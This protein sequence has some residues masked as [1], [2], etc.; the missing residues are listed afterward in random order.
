MTQRDWPALARVVVSLRPKGLTIES[1]GASR[2]EIQTPRPTAATRQVTIWKDTCAS[3]SAGPESAAWFSDLLGTDCELVW[4]PLG[5]ERLVSRETA[6]SSDRV[7]FADGFPFL[8]I[9]QGSLDDL[10]RRLDVP[11]PVDRFRPNLVV[12]GC[13]PY[14]EDGW[15]TIT[16]GDVTFTVVK[17]CARCIITTTDQRTGRRT[18]EPLRTLATYR[19]HG[20]Q[21]LFGQNLVHRGR[22][23]VRCGDVCRVAAVPGDSD[24]NR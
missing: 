7:G 16:I 21:L 4:L 10:N 14:A 1:E 11:V 20:G 24:F 9:S 18:P 8:L 23:V 17:P 5:E 3:R 22:G 13:T 19:S 6:R 2:L 12:D 15:T